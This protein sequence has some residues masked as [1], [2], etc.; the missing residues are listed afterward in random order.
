[1]NIDDA[2]KLIPQSLYLFLSVLISGKPGQPDED[3]GDTTRR[4]SV[5]FAQDSSIVYAISKSKALTPKHVGLEMTIH[6]ATRSRNLVTLLHNAVHSISY[7]QVQRV[8]TTL[9]QITVPSNLVEGRLLQFAAD[10]IDDIIEETLDGKGTFHA[11]Q[12]VAFQRGATTG[13]H[14]QV[15]PLGRKSTLNIPV[16]SQQLKHA[17]EVIARPQRDI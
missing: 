9:G 14:A 2:E 8:D 13:Q 11:T 15:L 10:N 16:E 6:Q 5:S 12:L 1:V 4:L 17:P 7:T 3:H